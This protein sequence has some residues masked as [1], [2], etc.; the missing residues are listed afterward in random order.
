MPIAARGIA[1]RGISLTKGIATRGISVSERQCWAYNF[2]GID[3]R[4][5]LASRAINIEGD[6]SLEFWSPASLVTFQCIVSQCNIAA[7]ASREFNLVAGSSG[8]I[9]GFGGVETVL[10]SQAQG[11]KVSTRYGLTLIGTEAKIYEGGLGGTL[12]RTTTFTRGTAREPTAPT[13]IGCRGNGAG[14]Y[15]NFFSGLQYD[16]KIN[17]T[18]WEMGDRNQS[19]QLP[20]PSGLGAELITQS[21]LENPASKGSQWTYLGGGRWSYVGDGSINALRFLADSASPADGF[22][23]FEVE[24]ISGG[25]M[26]CTGGFNPANSFGDKTFSTTGVKRCYYVGFTAANQFSFARNGSSD[27]VNCIIKNISFKPL[28]TCNPMQLI[29]TTSDRWQ[30]VPCR[31]NTEGVQVQGGAFITTS[32]NKKVEVLK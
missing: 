11:F 3:D 20:T 28:G 18:L 22:I 8:L 12:I 32:D 13:L 7:V 27:M 21:V 29:N 30:A 19:I 10:I 16:I 2:D 9:V 6:N 15:A 26:R 24:S 4:G 1:Q 31:I 14:S 23:E 5:V 17:G 25:T